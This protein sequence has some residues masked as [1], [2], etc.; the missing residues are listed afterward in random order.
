ML[1]NAKLSKSFWAKAA[2][3]TC[4]LINRSPSVAIDKK[5]L[6][7]LWFSPLTVYV[8]LKIFGYPAYA[9]I[10]NGKLELRYVKCVI[11]GYKNGVKGYK[12]LCLET[13]KITVSRDLYFL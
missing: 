13:R 9:R 8:D 6:I 11:L 7:E 3:R 12:L 4:F 10:D 2:S 5:T 1:S